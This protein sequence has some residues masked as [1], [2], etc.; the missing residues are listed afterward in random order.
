MEWGK[1]VLNDATEKGL[2]SEKLFIW[3]LLQHV[4]YVKFIAIY[5]PLRSQHFCE[6]VVI[7]PFR[8]VKSRD[9]EDFSE[10]SKFTFLLC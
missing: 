9:S 10:L 5:L 8:V 6:S 3:P 1:I 4:L 7:T 2:I